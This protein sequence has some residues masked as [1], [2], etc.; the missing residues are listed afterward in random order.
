MLKTQKEIL[1]NDN[2]ERAVA[3]QK[4]ALAKKIVLTN[5][6]LEET[7]QV[8]SDMPKSK[9]KNGVSEQVETEDNGSI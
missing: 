2:H 9:R 1:D 4:K 3:H 6:E 7:K 5:D 8:S